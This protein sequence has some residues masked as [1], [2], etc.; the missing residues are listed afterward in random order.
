MKIE[1]TDKLIIYHHVLQN[2]CKQQFAPHGAIRA[3]NFSRIVDGK[4]VEYRLYFHKFKPDTVVQ[5]LQFQSDVV[6]LLINKFRGNFKYTVN[7]A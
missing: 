6:L 1:A 5:R 7:S 2:I 4:S 3:K